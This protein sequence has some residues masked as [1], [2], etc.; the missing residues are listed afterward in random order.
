MKKIIIIPFILLIFVSSCKKY[1]RNDIVET[2]KYGNIL[3]DYG[4]NDWQSQAYLSD[5]DFSSIKFR[6]CESF[7]NDFGQN[8]NDTTTSNIDCSSNNI[9]NDLDNEFSV[10]VFPNPAKKNGNCTILIS[11]SKKMVGLAYSD[12]AKGGND[13][14]VSLV[15]FPKNETE[16]NFMEFQISQSIFPTSGNKDFELFIS[17]LTEDSCYNFTKGKIKW[18][19]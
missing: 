18:E 3:N 9:C 1:K 5:G 16:K 6:L 13:L 10:R 15:T 17:I 14:G 7:S 11:S 8:P 19:K 12:R 4:S 2:D